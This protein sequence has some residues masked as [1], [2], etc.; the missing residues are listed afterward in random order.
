[1]IIQQEP[2][3]ITVLLFEGMPT[4]AISGPIE[5]LTVAS[6]LAG[7]PQPQVNFVSSTGSK[8]QA[9]GGLTLTCNQH[10]REVEHCDIL[11]IGACGN[12]EHNVFILPQEMNQWLKK[13]IRR[14]S[15]VYSLCTGAFLLAELGV[16]NRKSA[17]THWVYADM[18]RKRY[19]EVKLMPQLSITHEGPYICTSSVKDYFSATM[20]I[21]D[22]LFGS[23]HREK[24]EQ[25]M[26]GEVS[27][28]QQ[29]SQTSF[30]QF[31]Q[32]SDELI[33]SL[34]DWMHKED[35]AKLS[36]VRC[37]E[38]SFLSERQMKRRF[39]AATKETPMNYIQRIRIMF[40]RDKL[41]TTK[42]N[43]DQ[44]CQ[45]VGYSDTNYFRMLFKKFYDI[46]PTQYRKKTQ[47]YSENK[48]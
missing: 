15:F 45:Q 4:T 3:S 18:F 35:P 43:V 5:M 33:H 14:T 21:I 38:K 47:V 2:L 36:V 39:K 12:P 48:A 6:S 46:T 22:N 25:F 28:I 11:L 19:P 40:A 8:V 23:A 34:Q 41:G 20:M 10:W 1:M 32:H 7:I 44:I 13:L 9:L 24:C 26:G 17:T 27:T 31:R 16:L 42:V 29:I 30:N 37:A